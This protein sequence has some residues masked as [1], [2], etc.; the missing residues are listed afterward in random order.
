MWHW[1]FPIPTSRGIAH[2]GWARPRRAAAGGEGSH[3][4]YLVVPAASSFTSLDDLRGKT[5]AFSDPNSHS[6]WL[7][8]AY[9]L[10]LMSETQDSFFARHIFTYHP[11][12]SVR[13]VA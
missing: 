3:Y 12:E 6:G 9:Q 8:P 7:A 10:A 13:A 4:S 2:S 5:F 1:V 11:R